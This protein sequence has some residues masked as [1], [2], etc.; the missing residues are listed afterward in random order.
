MRKHDRVALLLVLIVL[1]EQVYNGL[2]ENQFNNP[3]FFRIG[4]VFSNNESIEYFRD[5]LSV[6]NNH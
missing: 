1:N 3:T 5:T 4:G 2:T 6:S